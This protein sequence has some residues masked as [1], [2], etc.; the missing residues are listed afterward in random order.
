M[1]TIIE[2][3]IIID[4]EYISFKHPKYGVTDLVSPCVRG[5]K[6]KDGK[7][8]NN[9]F[10]WRWGNTTIGE[11]LLAQRGLRGSKY[12]QAVSVLVE[13]EEGK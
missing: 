7:V 1:S 4:E 10:A 2:C 12:E 11:D 6:Y 13:L 9:W 3:P 8:L 5:Y